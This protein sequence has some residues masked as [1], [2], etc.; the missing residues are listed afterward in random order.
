MMVRLRLMRIGARNSRRPKQRRRAPRDAIKQRGYSMPSRIYWLLPDGSRK[1]TTK[2]N[3][4]SKY[5]VLQGKLPNTQSSEV[6]WLSFTDY[7]IVGSSCEWMDLIKSKSMDHFTCHLH[8]AL[9]VLLWPE[10]NQTWHYIWYQ[11]E[12]QPQVL[13]PDWPP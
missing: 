1:V 10:R 12:P 11:G 7:C 9:G 3:G 13:Q 4:E 5:V 8:R 6:S 2:R